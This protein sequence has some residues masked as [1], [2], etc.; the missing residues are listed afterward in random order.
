MNE[1]FGLDILKR[2]DEVINKSKRF[3][4]NNETICACYLYKFF[5][6]NNIEYFDLYKSI[7]DKLN[8]DKKREVLSI[9]LILNRNNNKKEKNNNLVKRKDDIK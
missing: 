5:E 6:T 8:D 9:F 7:F 1:N 4:Q 2:V 3:L